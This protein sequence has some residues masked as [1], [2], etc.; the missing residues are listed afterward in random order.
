MGPTLLQRETGD[1]QIFRIFV[2]LINEFSFPLQACQVLVSG[3]LSER[4]IQGG[5]SSYGPLSH[6][7]GAEEQLLL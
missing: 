6:S 4:E 2:R 5:C 7:R 1:E 3:I